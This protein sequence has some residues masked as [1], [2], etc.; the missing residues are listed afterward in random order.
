MRN[1]AGDEWVFEF[2]WRGSGWELESAVAG[3]H[4]RELGG[5]TDG[6]GQGL[7]AFGTPEHSH[8]LEGVST[9]EDEG[10]EE[11]G[12]AETVDLLGPEYGEHFRPFLEHVTRM[13]NEGMRGA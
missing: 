11:S 3:S 4:G 5:L 2:R 6:E 12:G 1:T 13:A 8:G 7:K 10:A 9:E